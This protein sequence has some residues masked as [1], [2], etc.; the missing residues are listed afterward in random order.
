MK[1]P[2][3]TP[4][5][6]CTLCAWQLVGVVQCCN[7]SC[8][9]MADAGSAPSCGSDARPANGTCWP[10]AHCSAAVGLSIVTTGSWLPGSPTVIGTDA[11]DDSP[12]GSVTRSDAVT[13]AC[14]TYVHCGFA[15]DESS[16]SPSPSRSHA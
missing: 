7:V 11:V 1:L 15:A 6:D 5:K 4:S 9:R 16:Y 14:A 2:D 10:T 3:A 13:D 8:Q 12:P